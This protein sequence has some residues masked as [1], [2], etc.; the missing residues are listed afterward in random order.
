MNMRIVY[1]ICTLLAASATQAQLH[2]SLAEVQIQAHRFQ[3][4]RAGYRS[5]YIDSSI[6]NIY[7]T[8]SL[9]DL[10]AH[11]TPAVVRSYGYGTAAT[12]SLRGSTAEQTAVLWNGFNL[13]S[14]VLGLF[15]LSLFP[16]DWVDDITL[17]TGGNGALF[18]SGAVGGCVL[19]NTRLSFDKSWNTKAAFTLGNYGFNRQ[20]ISLGY[21]TGKYA[22]RAKTM[23]LSSRNDFSFANT[24]LPGNPTQRMANAQQLH[25]VVTTD[26]LWRISST[27]T[28][29]LNTW[30]QQQNMELPSAM[31]EPASDARQTD[32]ALRTALNWNLKRK[33]G[34]VAARTALFND[35]L[36]YT[37]QSSGI[38]SSMNAVTWVSEAEFTQKIGQKL[39]FQSGLHYTFARAE[40]S[41]YHSP[42]ELNRAAW[43]YSAAY[44]SNRLRIH[45]SGRIELAD[46]RRV[47]FMP[48]LGVEFQLHK[49]LKLTG[50]VA[51]SY[52]LPTLNE[53]YWQP[54]GNSQLLPESGWNGD[55]GFRI[56]NHWSHAQAE[57]G[58]NYFER[59]MINQIIWLMRGMDPEPLNA[60]KTYTQGA[61][62]YGRAA[63]NLANGIRAVWN[64]QMNY[65]HAQNKE[66]IRPGDNSADKYVIF[67]PR[68]THQHQLSIEHRLVS[69]ALSHQYTGMRYI[70]T[71]NSQSADAYHTTNAAV[72]YRIYRKLHQFA[73]TWHAFNLTNQAY[74]IM[75][76]RPMPGRNYQ[77]TISYTL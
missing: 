61:E 38:Q 70:T 7:H 23:R 68:L 13:Q 47:P 62:F 75:P 59:L 5:I 9:A 6:R 74:T 45:Q 42:K 15:N 46:G 48:A 3:Q 2:D 19:L 22:I 31:T 43:Y 44:N 26:Q 57:V 50:N 40:N 14:H 33:T 66:S 64:I 65:T 60:R 25:W 67:I 69:I 4:Y 11:T 53:M 52:R 12:V 18:G 56:L 37:K 30:W 24:S 77:F 41:G 32:Y 63:V 51:R 28:L 1:T 72:T 17:Q 58:V 55:V 35:K 16:V 49:K 27:Q 20:F 54:Y 39:R 29:Q 21:S 36:N 71:D 34:M 76:F 10:L 73:L 8:M